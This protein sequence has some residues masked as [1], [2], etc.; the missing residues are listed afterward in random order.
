MESSFMLY[1]YYSINCTHTVDQTTVVGSP[2]HPAELLHDTSVMAMFTL[3]FKYADQYMVGTMC[4]SIPPYLA[5][6]LFVH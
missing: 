2:Q 4:D 3:Q 1:R 6:I 5:H